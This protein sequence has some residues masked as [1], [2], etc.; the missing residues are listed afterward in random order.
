MAQNPSHRLTFPSI[1][2]LLALAC[3]AAASAL[4]TPSTA[5][6]AFGQLVR[7]D[8][9]SRQVAGSVAT[10]SR[11]RHNPGAGLLFNGSRLSDFSDQS[12]PGA[13]REVADPAGS[14]D[15]VF[16]M[17]VQDDDVYPVTPT[18]NPRAQLASTEFI[19]EGEEFWW[20][21]RFYLPKDFPSYLP[22][23]L[24]V[25]EG[26]YGRPWDGTPP[27][28]IDV[29]SDEIHWQRNDTYDWDIPWSAPIPRGQWTDVLYHTKFGSDGFV[30]MW[31]NDEPVTFFAT[32]ANNPNDEP[33][34]QHLEMATMDHTNDGG[35]GAVIIQNYRKVDMFDTVSLYH[36]ATQVG[37][38]R[39]SVAG[40]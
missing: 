14:G 38:T 17:T 7:A 2:A 16:K 25:M 39:A 11:A 4:A 36:G 40:Y 13:V 1:A 18:E 19:D 33:Q 10:T 30:E 8:V 5:S 9:H 20:H 28:S 35:H 22:S 29:N 23:W 12:A 26:P 21:A 34:T 15:S 24:T 31:V 3:I 27:V 32:D 37:T 6:A